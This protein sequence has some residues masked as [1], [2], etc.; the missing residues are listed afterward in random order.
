MLAMVN[1]L[2]V[3]VLDGGHILIGTYETVR[4][5]NLSVRARELITY[6]GLALVAAIVALALVADFTR[7][8]TKAG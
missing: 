6:V 1:L 3:P 7:V 4:G 2:P 8:F 5:K